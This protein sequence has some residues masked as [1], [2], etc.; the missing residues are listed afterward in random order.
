MLEWLNSKYHFDSDCSNHMNE[1]SDLTPTRG[2]VSSYGNIKCK[3]IGLRLWVRAI[4]LSL[5]CSD[6]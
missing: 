3:S 4:N 2:D 5:N 6:Y 1:F